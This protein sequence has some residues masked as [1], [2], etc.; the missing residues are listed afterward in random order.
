MYRVTE[1]RN[2]TMHAS[3]LLICILLTLCL[4]RAFRVSSIGNHNT[5]HSSR[6]VHC[7][8]MS[9]TKFGSTV[10]SVLKRTAVASIAALSLASG[11]QCL[12]SRYV[13]YTIGNFVIVSIGVWARP[14]GVNR[15]D[16]LPKEQTSVIDVAN[17]L[18]KG[19]ER[20]ISEK[21]QQ[22]EEKTGYKLRLLCQRY[23]N[24]CMSIETLHNTQKFIF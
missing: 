3:Y 6:H 12:P 17:F 19:Q 13:L 14:E 2:L 4:S 1:L 21:I 15:P 18:S 23:K 10:H 24:T 9:D 20:R 16:L 11:R 5:P 7:V 22:L 8:S